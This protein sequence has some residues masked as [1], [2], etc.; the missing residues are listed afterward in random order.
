VTGKPDR[1]TP[2]SNQYLK[3]GGMALQLF[4]LLGIGAWLGQLIDRKLGTPKPYFTIILILLFTAGFFYRLVKD[5][6][7][8]DEP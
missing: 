4:L 6:T 5:L 2:S 3:Y 7:R 8:K 1:S